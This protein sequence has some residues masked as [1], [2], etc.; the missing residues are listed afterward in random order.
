VC[1]SDLVTF[2]LTG[3]P[4]TLEELDAFLAGKPPEACT[5]VVDRLLASE[6]FGER[7]AADWLDVS[8]Y[9][10]T[11]GYQ[12][13]RD[14]FVWPWRD[15]VIRAFNSNMPYDDFIIQQ[16]AGDLLPDATDDQILATTF[17]RLHP[18]KVEGGSVPEEFRVEYVS[19]RTQT[20]GTAFLGLTLEC[21]R[22]HDH[23]YDPISTQE[24]Y[25]LF[26]FFDKIDEAGLYSYFTPAVPTPTLRLTDEAT[27]QKIAD[28]GK[29]IAET[30]EQF[31]ELRHVHSQRLKSVLKQKFSKDEAF[32]KWLQAGG[33]EDGEKTE[34]DRP[35]PLIPG[36]IKHLTFEDQAGGANASV[37]GK[38]GKA[39]R[40]S[41]DDGI[42]V[43]VGNFRRSQPFS[44][45][46]WLKTP[47]VK[48]RA[49]VFHR[50][51]AWTDAGSRGYE[52]LIEDGHLSCALIHFDPGNA[53]RI[54]TAERIETDEWILVTVTYD[55]SSR[56]SGLSLYLNGRPTGETTVRDNLY[57]NI[58]GGGGD[59]ITIG[60][61]FRDRGF[62]GGVVDEFRV[63][64][65]WLAPLE[66]EQIFSGDRL[67]AYSA[68]DVTAGAIQ[69][70]QADQQRPDRL[71]NPGEKEQQ[72]AAASQL[73]LQSRI[74]FR[75]AL[76]N[77]YQLHVH[78]GLPAL[79]KKLQELRAARCKLQD[80][81]QEIMVMRDLDTGPLEVPQRQTFVLGRG[82]YTQR[83]T[84][85][86]PLT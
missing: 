81:L 39:V 35:T 62:T 46:L 26:A 48:E 86:E 16:L 28:L 80:G 79:W 74:R 9:S 15:W 36:E 75:A 31:D 41:G 55:G 5:E 65:R 52:L 2:D 54:R 33:L 29:Q 22:C 56:A 73:E 11:Y 3:L 77:H 63:F 34:T 76:L 60:Q 78:P 66:V 84:P 8:R 14:R 10:D 21:C 20:M 71:R 37:A 70:L 51:R 47:D 64:D 45:S 43:G 12:V 1:S 53:L 38:V 27:R 50:S 68:R 82:L 4:P 42:N 19:D 44:I 7:M 85:V 23:K 13:D 83:T 25:Q 30:E 72:A 40:L 32:E 59:H 61:R 69:T 58:T 49:V 17:N 18:Q 57:R 6:R 67:T 24:Y